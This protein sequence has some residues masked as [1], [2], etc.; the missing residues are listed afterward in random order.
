MEDTCE[1]VLSSFVKYV[2]YVFLHFSFWNMN[3]V[4][5]YGGCSR[6]IQERLSVLSFAHFQTSSFIKETNKQGLLICC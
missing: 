4:V 6:H 5:S 1:F 2:S 3:M